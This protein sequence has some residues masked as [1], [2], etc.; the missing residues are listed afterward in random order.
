MYNQ[1]VVLFEKITL[2]QRARGELLRHVAIKFE[3]NN[4]FVIIIRSCILTHKLT[5][6]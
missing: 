2:A 5:M 6:V 1:L 3:W 4:T